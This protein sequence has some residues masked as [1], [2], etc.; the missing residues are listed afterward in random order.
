[1]RTL[2]GW[3]LLVW[4]CVTG[5]DRP[6]P[7]DTRPAETAAPEP[8][9]SLA[10]PTPSAETSASVP[11]AAKAPSAQPA[12]KPTEPPPICRRSTQTVVS[13][14]ADKITG[15]TTKG[16][17]RTLAIGF[18]ARG[19]PKVL[20]IDGLGHTTVKEVALGEKARMPKE[21][22]FYRTMLR[23]SPRAIDGE[24]ARA[25][26]DYRDDHKDK[27]R[28]IFCGPADAAES[29]L[30]YE[31]TSWLDLDPKPT[32]EEKAQRFS[33]KKLGGYVELRDCRTFV[34]LEQDQPW[35]LGSV[36]RGIE[37]PDGSNEWK[38]V[39]LVD[40][41]KGDDEIVLYEI[42]L[43]DD[44]PKTASFEIPTMRRVADKGYVAAS[45]F[46][47]S[48]VVAVLNADK[49]LQGQPKFY[50][51]WPTMTDIAATP[52]SLMLVAGVGLGKAKTL[53]GVVIS[54]DTLKLPD[55]YTPIALSPMDESGDAETQFTAPE[56]T[57]DSQGRS[58]LLYVEGPK[59][60][61]HLRIAPIGKDLQTTGRSFAITSD[62]DY[63]SEA[64]LH[65]LDDGRLMVA[66]LRH[67][68][69]KS[70]LVTEELACD[71]RD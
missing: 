61:G 31:G 18:A 67:Q 62:G 17:K 69:P 29:F 64:R 11:A 38:M 12:A 42:P 2:A 57:M 9:P 32:G 20:T 53:K 6:A 23:V 49:R 51:G 71:V 56:L 55:Q 60:K 10:P 24:L 1:M 25:F 52:E 65:A 40:F 8:S 39:W 21:K 27:R 37:K 43:K 28:H 19:V 35:A 3:G 26:L 59:D 58:W 4:I 7:S 41:G 46:G 5:C 33:W 22:G 14:E 45:R 68:G 13:S 66:Y 63:V 34:T 16:F 47:G 36:L 44:P 15:L 54:R 50:P 70:E 30:E 48:L